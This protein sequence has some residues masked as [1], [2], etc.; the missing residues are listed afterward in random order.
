MSA[1]LTTRPVDGQTTHKTTANVSQS[2]TTPT[3]T[4]T[5]DLIGSTVMES[6]FNY[7]IEYIVAKRVT[8][9][10]KIE[11]LVKWCGWDQRYCTWETADNFASELV[12]DIFEQGVRRQLAEDTGIARALV[13]DR[14]ATSQAM[15]AVKGRR[16][17]RRKLPT[18]TLLKSTQPYGDNT[19]VAVATDDNNRK[20]H[21]LS[22]IRDYERLL[23]SAN[24]KSAARMS[25]PSTPSTTTTTSDSPLVSSVA[26]ASQPTMLSPTLRS[27]RYRM[28]EELKTKKKSTTFSDEISLSVV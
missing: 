6:T 11:Y 14:T 9:G 1:S 15:M 8:A 4:T 23:G 28:R 5:D 10:G 3:T 25:C 19:A 22:V 17:R 27:V 13:I 16:G 20:S 2:T 24:L 18:N 21:I 26:A 7:I 12:A